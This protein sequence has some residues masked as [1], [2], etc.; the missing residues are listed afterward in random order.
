MSSDTP[1][2]VLK[3]L[4]SCDANCRRIGKSFGTV[5]QSL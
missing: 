4:D 5:K 2:L 1:P 3:K